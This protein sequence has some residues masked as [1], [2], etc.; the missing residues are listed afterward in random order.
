MPAHD[1]RKN[2]ILIGRIDER[3]INLDRSFT[4]HEEEDH[5]RFELVFSHMK[6]RFDKIDNKLELLW[7]EKNLRK[8][9]FTASSIGAS[10]L[11][12]IVVLVAGYFING[13]H[14]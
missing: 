11:W 2:D 3:L 13:V 9:A 5:A 6:E 12:A 14:R 7:D 1:R 4:S 10:S 8:G